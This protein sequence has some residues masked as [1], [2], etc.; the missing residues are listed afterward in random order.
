MD[1]SSKENAVGAVGT[2]GNGDTEAKEAGGVTPE[3]S[4]VWDPASET[5]YYYNNISG[6]TQCT[7]FVSE[8]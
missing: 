2:R 8:G 5:Y 7:L 1:A 6:A 3:W 4:K